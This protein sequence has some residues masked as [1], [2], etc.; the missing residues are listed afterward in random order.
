[1]EENEVIV[2]V[3]NHRHDRNMVS[4][5]AH[6]KGY[7]KKLNINGYVLIPYEGYESVGLIQCLTIGSNKINNP[8]RSR[9]CKLLL[10]YI[11]SGA[12]IRICH[13]LKN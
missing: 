8:I 4:I 11:S 5:N 2:E 12:T 13:T 7:K 1:M 6:S 3:R 9:K 10:E